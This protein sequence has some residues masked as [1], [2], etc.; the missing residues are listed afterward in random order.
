CVRALSRSESRHDRGRVRLAAFGRLADGQQLEAAQGRGAAPAQ[1]AVGVRARAYL[2]LDPANGGGRRAG[3][4][5]R[6]DGGGRGGPQH[7]RKRLSALGLRRPI[8]C[9]AA[10][11]E[12]GAPRENLLGERARA[13]SIRL[14]LWPG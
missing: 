1:G 6:G 2:G 12:R 7:V 10:E 13:L 4:S 9:A 11:S 14:S 3:A 8:P 5:R